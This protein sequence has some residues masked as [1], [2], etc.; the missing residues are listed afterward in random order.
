[1]QGSTHLA[2]ALVLL[3]DPMDLQWVLIFYFEQRTWNDP[4]VLSYSC[5]E[6]ANDLPRV[7]AS[8]LSES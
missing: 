7:T 8:G 3:R 1:M 5:N 4:W 2:A 6:G